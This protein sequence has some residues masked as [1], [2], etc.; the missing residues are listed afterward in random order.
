MR[1]VR[2]TAVLCG[3]V[4]LVP[5]FCAAQD[6][7]P[8]AG[9]AIVLAQTS[10]GAPD[11]TSPSPTPQQT[12]PPPSYPQPQ[13]QTRTTP[14]PPRP[15]I[16]AP[17]QADPPASQVYWGAIAFTASGAYFSTWKYLSRGEAEAEAAKGCAKYGRGG[18]EV[19]SFSGQQCVALATFTGRRWRLSFTA[20]ADTYPGSREAALNRCNADDRTGGRCQFRTAVCADGR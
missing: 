4:A 19:A 14:V 1:A 9:R 2:R 8:R 5:A 11:M 7:G 15:G 16:I 6:T 18:C 17:G 13:P 10:L 3:L 20:G 12:Q